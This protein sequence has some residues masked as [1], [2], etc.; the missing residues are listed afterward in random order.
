MGHADAVF[1]CDTLANPSQIV[2]GQLITA[3]GIKIQLL[4]TRL[5]NDGV[6]V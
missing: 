2:I 1:C 4:V 6:P 5:F 3:P